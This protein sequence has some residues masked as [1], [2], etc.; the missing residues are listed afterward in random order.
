MMTVTAHMHNLT[1]VK[2]FKNGDTGWAAF[3]SKKADTFVIFMPFETA[4]AL[5]AAFH[6]EMNAAKTEKEQH[7]ERDIHR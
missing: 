2:A 1:S 3:E 4:L 5:S 7:D 6:A